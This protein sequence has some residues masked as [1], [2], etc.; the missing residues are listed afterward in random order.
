MNPKID[1]IDSQFLQGISDNTFS[2]CGD[3]K[4]GQPLTQTN[5]LV[6]HTQHTDGGCPNFS[7]LPLLQDVQKL[8]DNQIVLIDSFQKEVIEEM[9]DYRETQ[10][11]AIHNAVKTLATLHIVY[12][13][14]QVTFPGLKARG[15][16]DQEI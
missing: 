10:M 2:E 11:E 12:K 8:I 9:A 6:T 13:Q 4:L 14:I 15:F 1:L 16:Q 5:S 3:K 7:S